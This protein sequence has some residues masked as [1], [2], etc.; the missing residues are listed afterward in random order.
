MECL[1]GLVVSMSIHAINSIFVFIIGTILGSFYN[2]VGYRL[3]NN[4]SIIFPNSKCPKCDHKLKF[5]ELIPIFSYI[6]LRGKCKKCKKNISISYPIFEFITGLLFLLTYLKFGLSYNFIFSITFISILI[7]I[8]ISDIKYYII[9]DEVLIAGSILLILEMIIKLFI[10]DLN[11]TTGLLLPLLNGVGAF[12]IIYLFKFI[13][14]RCL[15]KECLGGGDIKLLFLIGLVLGF[16]MS[17]VTI[18]IASFI[19]L[20]PSIIGLIKNNDN[21]LPFGPYLSMASIIILLTEMNLESIFNF[22]TI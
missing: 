6:F 19:A 1:K 15:K 5:Y 21:V 11:I 16:D 12:A 13:G 17:I 8:S 4:M 22:F 3:P 2:V 18:F 9:P 10:N 7:I 14:D 20:P